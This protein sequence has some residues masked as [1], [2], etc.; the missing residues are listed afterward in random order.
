MYGYTGFEG[1][2]YILAAR[3]NRTKQTFFFQQPTQ[4][5]QHPIHGICTIV[6][7]PM[8]ALTSRLN[9]NDIHPFSKLRQPEPLRINHFFDLR[10]IDTPVL[11]H[12]PN[13]STYIQINV[14]TVLPQRGQ[15]DA[16][17]GRKTHS[18]R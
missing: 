17:W 16:V 9:S 13:V 10:L 6:L 11:M 3:G 1:Q 14:N 18:L 2:E 7:G 5:Q 12:V 8:E 4:H 15:G